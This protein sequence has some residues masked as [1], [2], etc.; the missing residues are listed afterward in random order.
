L[1][2]VFGN[3]SLNL[4]MKR[5]VLI[6]GAAGQGVDKTSTLLG[7]IL[8]SYGL[9]CFLYR[10]YPSLI[11][12]G[13]NFSILTFSEDPIYSQ[14]DNFD[15]ILA[16]NPETVRNFRKKLKSGGVII[17]GENLIGFSGVQRISVNPFLERNGLSK[18]FGNNLLLGA[19]LKYLGSPSDKIDFFAKK[20]S[21]PK[22]GLF[23]QAIKE[24]YDQQEKSLGLLTR[25]KRKVFLSGSQGVARG[26]LNAGLQIGFFYPMT[27]ATG[28]FEQIQNFSSKRRSIPL[29]TLED[30]IAS[31]NAA[32]GANYA[33]SR[34][35][36]G[37]S[38][39][40]F[41]LMGEAVSLAGMTEIPLVIY[42][43]QRLGPATGVPT[44]T[45]QGDLGLALNIGHGEFPRLVVVPGDAAECV[46][47][48]GEAFYL[49]EKYR[50]PAI[51]LSDKHLAESY[52]S[53]EGPL[54][55]SRFLILKKKRF[56]PGGA[57]AARVNSY[58]H[59]EQGI[60]TDD[61]TI[62]RRNSEKRKKKA[63]SLAKEINRFNPVALFGKGSRLIISCGSTK[64]AIIDAIKELRGV[65][66]M[67][68]SYLSPFP[69]DRVSEEIRKAEEVFLIENNATG[70]LGRIIRENTGLKIDRTILKFDG[71]PFLAEEIIDALKI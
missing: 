67:Q 52:F 54:P 61:P 11:R 6:G 20:L 2:V 4:R 49:A 36:V 10:D 63:A 22:P 8:S 1:E 15:V 17:A 65:K 14:E 46:A 71:R 27:P 34:T 24:G 40:G 43:A 50:L 62:I 56:L 13:Q 39:G 66:F 16:L 33:G 44:Y 30:E 18:V 26:A 69:T 51:I 7:E 5:S 60:T 35:M 59:D 58:E 47:R 23:S 19:L 21:L 31:V 3:D 53:F 29:I 38:G 57:K 28:V 25:T 12:G 42:L 32:L 9:F 41:D 68:I 37:T 70:L 48:T 64:G 45:C 55:K